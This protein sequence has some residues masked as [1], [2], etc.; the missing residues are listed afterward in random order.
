MK[1]LLRLYDPAELCLRKAGLAN[2]LDEWEKGLETQMMK[3]IH[4]DG[5]N[6]SGEEMQK[7]GLAKALYKDT[8][9]VVLDKP[10]AALNPVS[11]YEI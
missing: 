5:V 8:T 4:N 1:L 11:E 10:T 2:K 7:M 3:I 6:L 9:I